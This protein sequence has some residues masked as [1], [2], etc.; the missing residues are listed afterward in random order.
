MSDLVERLY[1]EHAAELV[2]AL[3]LSTD[4]PYLAEGTAHETFLRAQTA[5]AR[6]EEQPAPR[7]WL[8]QTA[9]RLVRGRR[10]SPRPRHTTAE[11]HPILGSPGLTAA[12]PL[13]LRLKELPPAQRDATV[14]HGLLDVSLEETAAMLGMSETDVVG[15]VRA[16][17]E[18]L[19]QMEDARNTLNRLINSARPVHPERL[20]D[21]EY[22]DIGERSVLT[23]LIAVAALV[24]LA[25]WFA[26]RLWTGGE[27]PTVSQ[28]PPPPQVTQA[29]LSAAAPLPV[30]PSPAPTTNTDATSVGTTAC[31]GCSIYD[32]LE[33]PPPVILR[34][35]ARSAGHVLH[36]RAE[37]VWRTP[38]DKQYDSL[39][40]EL[41]LDPGTG[42]ARY[43]ETDPKTGT[44]TIHVRKGNLYSVLAPPAD[45][46]I[47]QT[48]PD[49]SDPY[50]GPPQDQ[51]F[52][53]KPLLDRG[54]IS[55]AKRVRLDGRDAIVFETGE[56]RYGQNVSRVWVDRRTG[57]LLREITYWVNIR[58]LPTEID[59][60]FIRYTVTERLPR[61][62]L[63]ESI[64]TL[65]RTP[66]E[67]TYT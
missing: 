57:M 13:F 45:E 41:W 56:Y 63:P 29:P 15:A 66:G 27:A 54:G 53:Y 52:K 43:E 55:G 33:I 19:G 28:A 26:A 20:E 64:F 39:R 67:R 16:A 46:I 36:L 23:P 5:L 50:A 60:H 48:L 35:P 37:H 49:A 51:V 58:N 4:D 2:A 24:M 10:T 25:G 12:D 31:A 22:V 42:N 9:Y 40:T 47:T 44:R 1:T 38:R 6:L 34:A 11:E 30:S 17:C 59:R 18:T 62:E 61:E 14:L 21:L 7:T 3:A 32:G 8:F 65:V